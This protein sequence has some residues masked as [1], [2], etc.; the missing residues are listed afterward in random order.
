MKVGRA[1]DSVLG[2]LIGQSV[3]ARSTALMVYMFHHREL[4]KTHARHERKHTDLKAYPE[5]MWNLQSSVNGGQT[6]SGDSG[7]PAVR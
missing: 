5:V 2:R 7:L 6:F 1:L 4:V 3:D